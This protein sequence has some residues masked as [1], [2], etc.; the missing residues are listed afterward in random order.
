MCRIFAFWW[1]ILSLKLCIANDQA[2][3]ET[4][5]V[6]YLLTRQTNIVSNEHQNNFL[7]TV[8]F[9]FDHVFFFFWHFLFFFQ[10][11][12]FALSQCDKGIIAHWTEAPTNPPE[13]VELRKMTLLF[14]VR[15]AK[16]FCSDQLKTYDKF[17][18]SYIRW[19]LVG[20]MVYSG[21]SRRIRK[22]QHVSL[23]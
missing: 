13:K 17:S 11:Q 23:G 18:S 2:L 7:S 5:T 6:Q 19:G 4:L 10:I 1:E 14:F 3:L 8:I 12:F 20:A 21:C 9:K 22:K 16:I 15:N